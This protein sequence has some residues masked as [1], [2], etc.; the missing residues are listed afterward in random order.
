MGFYEVVRPRTAEHDEVPRGLS[1]MGALLC[2]SEGAAQGHPHGQNRES[3]NEQW[4]F[5]HPEKVPRD[6]NGVS[7]SEEDAFH[8]EKVP[9][10]LN[11]V[12]GSEEDAFHLEKVPRGLNRE[13]VIYEY[14]RGVHD[15]DDGRH[16][17]LGRQT[18]RYRTLR[19][20]ADDGGGDLENRDVALPDTD[21]VRL[22]KIPRGEWSLVEL[23]GPVSELEIAIHTSIRLCAI[24]V[25]SEIRAMNESE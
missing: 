12:S 14:Q 25:V 1:T 9:H 2:G 4:A 19:S 18:H 13:N 21:E 17:A 7:G 6:L 16:H 10:D 5:F 3:V 15:D 20:V 23:R 8:L 22:E 24:H 11:G